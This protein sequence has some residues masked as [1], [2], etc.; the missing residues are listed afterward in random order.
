MFQADAIILVLCRLSML[1]LVH[2]LLV[3][4]YAAAAAATVE[5]LV[6]FSDQHIVDGAESWQL[7]RGQV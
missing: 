3:E 5:G 1:M 7:D 2:R 4:V 6:D